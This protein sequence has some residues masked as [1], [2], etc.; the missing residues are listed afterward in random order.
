MLDVPSVCEALVGSFILMAFDAMRAAF[1][2]AYQGA[3]CLDAVSL[4]VGGFILGSVV[5]PSS[6]QVRARSYGY[7]FRGVVWY[8]LLVWVDTVFALL[9]VAYWL[10]S[11][12]A[13]AP[14]PARG[15]GDMPH[16]AFGVG[17]LVCSLLYAV[18]E[19]LFLGPCT[20]AVHGAPDHNRWGVTETPVPAKSQGRNVDRSFKSPAPRTVAEC[21]LMCRCEMC[22][23]TAVTRGVTGPNREGAVIEPAARAASLGGYD[24]RRAPGGA[25]SPRVGRGTA[26]CTGSRDP[27]TAQPAVPEVDAV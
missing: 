6:M 21:S 3:R 14:D 23:R 25:L 2:L 22:D 8:D 7:A 17:G 27:G 15:R 5:V 26:D 4:R 10:F 12:F 18:H 9:A 24:D 16:T 13:R 11:K 19:M 1:T 20:D